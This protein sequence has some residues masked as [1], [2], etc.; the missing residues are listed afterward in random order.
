[1]DYNKDI[2]SVKALAKCPVLIE[3]NVYATKVKDVTPLT[4]QNIIVNWNP[5]K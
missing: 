5:V 1:M 4:N 3:V 2:S